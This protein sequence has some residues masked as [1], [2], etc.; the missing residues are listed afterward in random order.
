MW[1]H[2][3]GALTVAA[4]AA[5]TLGADGP[6][7]G[8]ASGAFRA[9]SIDLL[10][11]GG[12]LFGALACLLLSAT[13]HLL[14]DTSLRLR[15]FLIKLDF[16]GV[17]CL[18]WG[19][20]L[21]LLQFGLACRDVRWRVTYAAVITAGVGAVAVL[22]LL[23]RFATPAYQPV[24]A[25]VFMFI[26][27]VGAVPAVQLLADARTRPIGLGVIEMGLL[28]SV[29]TAIDVLRMPERF[30][31]AAAPPSVVLSAVGGA[32]S[33]GDD[34]VMGSSA[35]NL[36]AHADASGVASGCASGGGS[37]GC[38]APSRGGSIGSLGSFGASSP[39]RSAV[40]HAAHAPCAARAPAADGARG[41]ARDLCSGPPSPTLGRGHSSNGARADAH[42]ELG[43]GSGGGCHVGGPGVP[44]GAGS[45]S[46]S[47]SMH[48]LIALRPNTVT[49]TILGSRS[50]VNLV[51][52]GPV[53]PEVEAELCQLAAQ[54]DEVGTGGDRGCGA[55]GPPSLLPPHIAAMPSM[56]DHVRAAQRNAR[57]HLG[58]CAP[59]LCVWGSHATFHCFVVAAVV[60]HYRTSMIA[61]E[62]KTRACAA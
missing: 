51:A 31:Y 18:V 14:C 40:V 2:L 56:L 59:L 48:S 38:L 43:G 5:S 3:C 42:L 12:F 7:R 26:G 50:A 33:S 19:S 49:A 35:R 61:W 4:L 28:Y 36:A 62:F 10:A 9:S 21:P 16:A 6:M 34:G 1:T 17:L 29:G 55:R 47:A 41:W 20:W 25:G 30:F 13:F 57:D 37:I 22:C 52:N 44:P 24:R 11:E 27:W 54:D 32:K 23:P 46:A 53:E 58:A 39:T 45:V 60:T 15:R 8:G